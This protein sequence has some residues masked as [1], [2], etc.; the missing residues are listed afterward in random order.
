LYLPHL[1]NALWNELVRAEALLRQGE[2][3]SWEELDL[4]SDGSAEI[5][6]HGAHCS[7]VFSR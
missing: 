6:V 5:W 7:I 2:E 3:L 4:D 1:R